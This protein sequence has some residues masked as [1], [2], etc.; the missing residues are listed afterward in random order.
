MAGPPEGLTRRWCLLI[1]P[2]PR[3]IEP[4]SRSLRRS[5]LRCHRR[6]SRVAAVSAPA[7]NG[8]CP[9]VTSDLR[10]KATDLLVETDHR[11]PQLN[12]QSLGVFIE[13]NNPQLESI[14]PAPNVLP[15]QLPFLRHQ[16][17]GFRAL[18][19]HRH[20]HRTSSQ[21]RDDSLP[22][23]AGACRQLRRVLQQTMMR[24]ERLQS[25]R[26]L[27]QMPG[28]EEQRRTLTHPQRFHRS[29]AW[30]VARRLKVRILETMSRSSSPCVVPIISVLDRT[31]S[32]ERPAVGRSRSPESNAEMYDS[33]AAAEHAR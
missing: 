1:A 10:S 12:G 29:Q 28:D 22:R 26:R 15:R 19:I 5:C 9:G 27:L 6:A 7:T 11:H 33:D 4:Q 32:H 23:S 17:H 13:R 18:A 21:R 31:D 24:A 2:T 20:H 14:R 30:N 25:R 3:R 16:C 8:A